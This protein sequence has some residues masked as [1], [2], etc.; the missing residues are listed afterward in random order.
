MLA[1]PKPRRAKAEMLLTRLGQG[2]PFDEIARN[3]SEDRD[4]TASGGDLGF[5][6]AVFSRGGR[7]YAAPRGG[8]AFPRRD[9]A[10]YSIRPGVSHPTFDFAGTGR[11]ARVFRPAR[12]A[13][14]SRDAAQPQG[15]TLA[16]GL[17]RDLAESGGCDELPG[18]THCGGFWDLVLGRGPHGGQPGGSSLWRLRVAKP[19]PR[20]AGRRV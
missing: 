15:S 14:D 17:Y 18:A 1:T 4:S 2:D 7:Y 12:P 11:A 16:D 9:L 6:P 10:D 13:V 8:L 5:Y 20:R 19:A 3:F